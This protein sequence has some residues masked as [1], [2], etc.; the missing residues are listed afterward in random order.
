MEGYRCGVALTAVEGY[1]RGLALTEV[2]GYHRGWHSQRWRAIAVGGIQRWHTTKGTGK[3]IF[4][5]VPY[6]IL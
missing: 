5:P 1:R 2:E 4:S 3:I 6:Y